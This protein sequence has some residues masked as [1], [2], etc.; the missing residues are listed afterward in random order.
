MGSVPDNRHYKYF[1]SKFNN[2]INRLTLVNCPR[3]ISM[4]PIKNGI[5]IFKGLKINLG[6]KKLVIKI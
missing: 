1:I 4:N 6:V 3:G 2:I 5:N